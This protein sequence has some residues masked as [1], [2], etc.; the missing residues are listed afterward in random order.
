MKKDALEFIKSHPECVLATVSAEG[1]PEAATLLFA[2]DDDFTFYFGTD[3]KY[4][5]YQNILKNKNAAVV[6]GV[7]SKEPKSAQIEGEI[8]ILK[9][10]PDITKARKIFEER[11][12]AMK[13]FL[14][15]PL[16]F[17]RLKPKWLRF[18]DETKGGVDNFEQI[19]P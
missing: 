15:L 9:S 19:I 12:P 1:K 13:P 3:K 7:S 16:V 18:L 2:M 17:L 11:N 5:K 4:R 10:A 8:E 14:D 6:V